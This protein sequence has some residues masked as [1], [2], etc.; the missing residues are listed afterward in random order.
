MDKKKDNVNFVSTSSIF[1]NLDLHAK[2][3][4]SSTKNAMDA[5]RGNF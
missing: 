1:D 3:M 2:P 4:G 5:S